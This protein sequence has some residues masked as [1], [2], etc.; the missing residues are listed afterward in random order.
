VK[1]AGL[2]GLPPPRISSS[3]IVICCDI[4]GAIAGNQADIILISIYPQIIASISF[5]VLKLFASRTRVDS[6]VFR[7]LSSSS[8]SP[9]FRPFPLNFCRHQPPICAWLDGISFWGNGIPCRVEHGIF[10]RLFGRKLVRGR[11]RRCLRI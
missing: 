1:Y 3:R 7:S 4:S 5:P 2:G 6:S 10:L 11:Y 9:R 8:S